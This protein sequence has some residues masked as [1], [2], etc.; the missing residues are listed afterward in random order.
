MVTLGTA[1]ASYQNACLNCLETN[2]VD[3]LFQILNGGGGKPAGLLLDHRVRGQ[4][5]KI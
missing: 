4:P 2:I 1:Y 5:E 3:V